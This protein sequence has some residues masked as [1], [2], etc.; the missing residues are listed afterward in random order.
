[1][2]NEN[3]IPLYLYQGQPLPR[4]VRLYDYVICAQ[5]I[6]KRLETPFVSADHLLAPLDVTLTGLRLAT[7][8]LPPLRFKLPRIPGQLLQEVLVDARQNLDLEVLYQFRFDPANRCWTASRPPQEQAKTRVGYTSDPTG[9]ILDLHSHN[10][11]PAFFSA[12]DDR[13]EMGA[14]FYAVIGHLER[15][16]PELVLRLGLHGHWLADVPGLTL[17]DDLGPFVQVYLDSNPPVEI[18][19]ASP[20]G[21]WLSNLFGW[22]A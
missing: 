8:P 3:L 15:P 13:D 2:F 19:P 21:G 17:F 18:E 1:M 10:S 16:Q 9:V 5:G 22:R 12:T 20:P 14:R 7:Y 11:L 4:P 6:V